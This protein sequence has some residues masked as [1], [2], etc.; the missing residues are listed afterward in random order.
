MRVIAR[1]FRQMAHIRSA[2]ALRVKT[3]YEALVQALIATGS[4]EEAT[5]IYWDVRLSERF[6]TVEFRVTD[7]CM[8]V[9]EAV[10]V[11]GL[12]RALVRTCYK[13]S[14]TNRSQPP[15]LNSCV[16]LTGALHAM[17]WIQS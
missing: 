2:A 8:T 17:A 9:D 7:V 15:A 3:E 14:E 1:K 16:L 6:K 5:K 11:A 10:M 12:T 13:R 4:V